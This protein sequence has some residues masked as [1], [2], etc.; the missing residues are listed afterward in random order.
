MSTHDATPW[1]RF[2]D[3]TKRIVAVP[4]KDVEKAMKARRRRRQRRQTKGRG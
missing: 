4:K 3:A 2:V 1:E